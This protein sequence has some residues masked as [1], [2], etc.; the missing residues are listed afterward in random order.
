MAIFLVFQMAAVRHL[1]FVM[2]MFGPPTMSI[3]CLLLCK[4]VWNRRSNVDSMQVL[5]EFGIKMFIHASDGGFEGLCRLMGNPTPKILCIKCF[6]MGETPSKSPL[7]L[8]VSGH[9]SLCPTESTTQTASRLVQPFL[10]SSR[11]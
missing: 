1:E 3:W 2:C 9:G 4:I 11:Q 5:T 8:W 6:S 7:P 10:H